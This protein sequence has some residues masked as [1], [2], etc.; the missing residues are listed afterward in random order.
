M[1]SKHCGA[2]SSEDIQMTRAGCV[3]DFRI[4]CS[5]SR[6]CFIR[7]CQFNVKIQVGGLGTDHDVVPEDVA[8]EYPS[9]T[10]VG[11]LPDILELVEGSREGHD[12]FGQDLLDADKPV[13][14]FVG[15]LTSIENQVGDVGVSMLNCKSFALATR[16][17]AGS[18]SFDFIAKVEDRT[19]L[20][21][22]TFDE[23]D[24]H[25]SSEDFRVAVIVLRLLQIRNMV[26]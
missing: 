12:G 13:N 9:K 2:A 17:L 14:P 10:F 21:Q 16:C 4:S 1:R 6:V 22:V 19:S 15:H 20:T 11:G 8:L 18:L 24:L 25:A 5:S 26:V 7:K 3:G 23:V